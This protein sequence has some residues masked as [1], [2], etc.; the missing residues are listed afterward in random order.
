MEDHG[1]IWVCESCMLHH[2]NGECGCC[3]NECD[4]EGFEPLSLVK[5]SDGWEVFHGMRYS[6]HDEECENYFPE[7]AD[8]TQASGNIECDCEIN[9]YS[10]SQCEGCGS[11]LHGERHAMTLYKI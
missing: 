4:H 2:A 11:Y 5:Y 10:T 6:E 8:T 3:H 9:T 1:T 7:D